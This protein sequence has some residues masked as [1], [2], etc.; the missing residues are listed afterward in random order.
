M[1]EGWDL[2][3]EVASLN[4][5]CQLAFVSGLEQVVRERRNCAKH[6]C[7]EE[8]HYQKNNERYMMV[9]V[10]YMCCCLWFLCNGESNTRPTVNN[11]NGVPWRKID[12]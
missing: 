8:F 9:A 3:K 11:T 2:A 7:R 6:I 4:N 5:C 10:L 12:D 1:K